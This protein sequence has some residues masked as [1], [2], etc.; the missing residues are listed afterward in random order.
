VPFDHLPAET[1]FVGPA[2]AAEILGLSRS[3]TY[4][5]LKDEVIHSV[6]YGSRRL[7]PVEELNRFADEL[8]HQGAAFE[9]P[10]DPV[11][12]AAGEV[13][14]TGTTATYFGTNS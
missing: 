5:L 8:L 4:V 11:G 9:R 3:T 10:A 12:R 6:R 7:I 2:K 14:H 1:R 13:A